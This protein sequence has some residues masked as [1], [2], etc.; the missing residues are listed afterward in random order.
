MTRCTRWRCGCRG[1]GW[2]LRL[3]WRRRRRCLLVESDGL[4]SVGINDFKRCSLF[5]LRKL[6]VAVGLG[7]RAVGL[8]TSRP[9]GTDSGCRASSLRP[10]NA[11]A[12][13]IRMG[14]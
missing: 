8:A 5:L 6:E 9:G 14:D 7:S 2:G 4:S 11:R 12:R 13:S 3:A 10:T 1:D